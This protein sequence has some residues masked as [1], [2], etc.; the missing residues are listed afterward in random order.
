MGS[1]S[2]TRL[3]N[4]TELTLCFRVYLL[5]YTSL[6]FVTLGYI[7]K[8]SKEKHS[9]KN[10]NK[11]YSCKVFSPLE[12]LTK[13]IKLDEIFLLKS[14][15][16]HFIEAETLCS[17]LLYS[18]CVATRF[19]RLKMLQNTIYNNQCLSQQLFVMI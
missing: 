3:S 10:P 16:F 18:K 8:K 14:R 7:Q 12:H 5:I 13:K 2:W 1:Q 6:K 17:F 4:W 15:F 19:S 9:F 11:N